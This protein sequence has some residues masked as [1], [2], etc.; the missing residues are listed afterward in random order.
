MRILKVAHIVEPYAE[1]GGFGTRIGMTARWLQ[2]RGHTVTVAST[3]CG[4]R[5]SCQGTDGPEMVYLR[6]ALQYR[7]VGVGRAMFDFARSR[8]ADFD[9]VHIY[10]NYS[11]LAPIIIRA[12]RRS[13]VP[14]VF[15]P[16]GSLPPAVRGINRKRAYMA[17]LGRRVLTAASAV[18]AAS[19]REYDQ[20]A[21]IV[22]GRRLVLRRN[23][24]TAGRVSRE[25]VAEW[26]QRLAQNGVKVVL[27]LGRICQVKAVEVLV[28]ACSR[29]NTPHVLVL[30]GP[31]D[32]DGTLERALRSS[33]RLGVEVRVTGPV[34]ADDRWDLLA[35]ADVVALPSFSESFGL[36]AAEAM[37]VGVPVVVSQN[38][39]IA[40]W[41]RDAGAGSVV[42]P[43]PAD[44]A[45]GLES[46]LSDQAARAA[47]ARGAL[48]ATDRLGW[49]VPL[50]LLERVYRWVLDGVPGK[51]PCADE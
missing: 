22:P 23:G 35:A 42:R 14:H 17:T 37:A 41:V 49:D 27:F 11:M 36:A 40:S 7:R 33:R 44:L 12:A 24:V 1:A 31:A 30:A 10:G 20:L 38:T 5:P 19:S 13:G 15:E 50:Q 8:V 16:A 47:A 32:G 18:V 39:G 9:I 51:P 48:A 28:E 25:R 3:D 43:Q 4:P 26:R 29:V 2:Q 46:L 45:V 34:A 6:A 21:Q